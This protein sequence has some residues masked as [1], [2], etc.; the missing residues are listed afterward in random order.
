MVSI[1]PQVFHWVFLSSVKGGI[2]VVFILLIKFLLRNK[3]DANWHYA[4][5]FIL[6]LQLVV[7]WA[8]SNPLGIYKA[9]PASFMETIIPSDLAPSSNTE[10][11]HSVSTQSPTSDSE[12]NS[13]TISS[14]LPAA[15]E[16]GS[17][18]TELKVHTIWE[19]GAWLWL[20]GAAFLIVWIFLAEY[21]FRKK[22]IKTKPVSE[23]RLLAVLEDC[24][25]L[26]GVSK[27]IPLMETDTLK[28]PALFGV[29]RTRLLLPTGL[30]N[31]LTSEQL[32][33]I[34]LHELVHFKR[35]DIAVNWI[36]AALR[37]LHWFNPLI[38][39]GLKRWQ[40]D[41]EMSR[42]A[43]AVKYLKPEAVKDYG[44]TLIRVLE[45][46]GS[47]PP[48][49]ISTVGISGGK[50]LSKRR[51][52]MITLFKKRSFK[53]SLLGAAAIIAVA[54][55]AMTFPN[56]GVKAAK[57][58]T[59]PAKTQ[60]ELAASADK[61][62]TDGKLPQETAGQTA[63]DSLVY[64][65]TEYGF[66]FD[67][68]ASWKGYSIITDKWE[69]LAIGGN[70][71]V[72]TGPMISIR[73]PL[74]T[75]ENK[76]Q[77]IPVMIFT[78][79]QW[80]SLQ[81]DEFHIGAAPIRP[82][83]LGRNNGYVFALPARYNYA[84]PT[85]Y[86]EVDQ[87]FNNKPLKTENITVS[88]QTAESEVINLEDYFPLKKGSKWVYQGTGNE[89]ASFSREV[90]FTKG[91]LAQALEINGGADVTKIYQVANDAVIEIFKQEEPS[92]PVNRLNEKINEQRIILKSPLSIGTKWNDGNSQ[93]EIIDT[94]ATIETPAG[95][96]I[97]CIKV[98]S[99]SSVDSSVMYQYYAKGIGMVEQDFVVGG[100]KISSSLESY[101]LVK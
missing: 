34:F 37:V 5:W 40:D 23:P 51:I 53:W 15:P 84:F 71:T 65:N 66:S 10:L 99:T 2:L 86:E 14:P 11:S 16:P 87:I 26:A 83:E 64:R 91:S 70:Q 39:Y 38:W 27:T 30:A 68:P 9:I 50:S 73:H 93:L 60:N 4:V 44:R 74:W 17:A 69:G 13:S 45:F 46:A 28:S 54:V 1:L 90:L 8:P 52:R 79:D 89:Y 3:L 82:S 22:I 76:R 92:E 49:L 85:G 20:A 6:F 72:E 94:A 48:Q 78:L 42:D 41:Q 59:P 12:L 97:N 32:A 77:D 100:E 95:T 101:H 58:D 67:L 88:K 29:F 24:K 62:G 80:N 36:A 57:H 96:F 81:Q 98:K 33:H 47:N 21:I 43:Q 55:I 63:Q 61:K 35:H 75:S 25:L 19:L 7:P 18:Y 31:S 56:S